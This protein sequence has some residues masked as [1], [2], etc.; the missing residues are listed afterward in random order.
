MVKADIV[1]KVAEAHPGLNL[2]EAAEAV[3]TILDAMKNTL[4]RGGRVEIRGFAVLEPRPK[5]AGHGRNLKTGETVP[6]PAGT[7]I[8][9]KPG[10]ELRNLGD[11]PLLAK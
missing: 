7:G 4:L 5:K 8:R 11:L 6:I 1:R 3:D 2:R 10:K 9:F